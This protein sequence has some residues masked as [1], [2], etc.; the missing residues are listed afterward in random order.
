MGDERGVITREDVNNKFKITFDDGSSVYKIGTIYTSSSVKTQQYISDIFDNKESKVT[1][2]EINAGCDI[3]F[4]TNNTNFSRAGEILINTYLFKTGL[5]FSNLPNLTSITVAEGNANFS[6]N[7][8]VLFSKDGTILYAYPPGK[9]GDKYNIPSTVTKIN[10]LSFMNIRYLKEPV[11]PNNSSDT[12]WIAAFANATSLTKITIPVNITTIYP[13]GFANCKN[14]TDFTPSKNNRYYAGYAFYKCIGLTTL[15]LPNHPDSSYFIWFYS[16]CFYDCTN[17][18]SITL[19]NNTK[20]HEFGNIFFNCTSLLSI[21]LP[22]SVTIIPKNTFY[23]CTSLSSVNFPDTLSEIHTFAFALC[24]QLQSVNLPKTLTKLK[25]GVFGI[26]TSLDTITIPNTVT[27]IGMGCFSTCINL[28]RVIFGDGINVTILNAAMFSRCIKLN[29]IT[30]PPRVDT[31]GSNCFSGT[32][33]LTSLVFPN[34]IKTVAENAFSTSIVIDFNSPTLAAVIPRQYYNA[35]LKSLYMSSIVLNQL[36]LSQGTKTT[37]YSASN[38]NVILLSTAPPNIPPIPS[39]PIIAEEPQAETRAELTMVE[40][41]PA[42]APAPAPAPSPSPAPAPAPA[43][44]PS[45][46]IVSVSQIAASENIPTQDTMTTTN[47][48]SSWLVRII[49]MICIIILLLVILSLTPT[50]FTYN[51]PFLSNRTNSV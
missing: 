9:T 43:P 20:F 34:S 23:N 45:P 15:T 35:G 31:L 29:D 10:C 28:T 27:E 49:V 38:V 18:R 7:N 12:V 1:A 36:Q 14:L 25:D 6:S 47:L 30:I 26:C 19:P 41:T 46:T 11:I 8:G 3:P 33:A 24:R 22:S 13:Y 5:I 42:P 39:P 2:I 21:T 4:Y 37:L 16:G 32:P 44:A 40:P 17:L 51:I 50:L 48:S